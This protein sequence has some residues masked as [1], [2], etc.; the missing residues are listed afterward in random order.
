MLSSSLVTNEE[1]QILRPGMENPAYQYTEISA[2]FDEMKVEG[3]Y[4][5]RMISCYRNNIS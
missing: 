1:S 3:Y 5:I 2:T 4:I